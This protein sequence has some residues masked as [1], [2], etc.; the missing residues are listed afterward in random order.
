MNGM[1]IDAMSPQQLQDFWTFLLSDLARDDGSVARQHLEAGNPIYVHQDDTP[2]G[3]TEKRF[4]DG[5]RQ[6]VKWDLAGEHVV[7][8]LPAS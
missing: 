1:S 4:P 5:R 6:W 8:E 7:K 2:D 3:L